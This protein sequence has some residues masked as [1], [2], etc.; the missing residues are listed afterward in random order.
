MISDILAGFGFLARPIEMLDMLLE[1][2]FVIF[3]ELIRS[4][5]Y[6]Q[7]LQGHDDEAS[8][9]GCDETGD[10]MSFVSSLYYASNVTA[11]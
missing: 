9:V 8:V 2:F 3:T 1:P 4:M 7:T 6:A 10:C 5:S 11:G